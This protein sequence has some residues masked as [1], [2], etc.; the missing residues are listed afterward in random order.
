MWLCAFLCLLLPTASEEYPDFAPGGTFYET[1]N[2]ITNATIK[3]NDVFGFFIWPSTDPSAFVNVAV[4]PGTTNTPVSIRTV[5]AYTND[6]LFVNNTYVNGSYSTFTTEFNGLTHLLSTQPYQVTAGVTYHLKLALAD[7]RDQYIDSVVYLRAGSIAFSFPPPPPPSPP[8]PP[9][10]PSPPPNPPPV[11]LG[12]NSSSTAA[13][14]TRSLPVVAT[15]GAMVVL[16]RDATVSSRTAAAAADAAAAAASSGT[17]AGV[18]YA[19]AAAQSAGLLKRTTFMAG[20]SYYLSTGDGLAVGPRAGV[21][22]QRAFNWT[23]DE[24]AGSFKSVVIMAGDVTVLL[25]S[26]S[27]TAASG[28]TMPCELWAELTLTSEVFPGPGFSGNYDWQ[29]RGCARQWQGH[30]SL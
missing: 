21:T 19:Q 22:V 13:G 1:V 6:Q 30:A 5:N 7:G 15:G 20:T 2:P 10:S 17:A 12:S 16:G 25:N 8:P 9:P 11:Q 24:G 23:W 27:G 18:A 3:P 28:S 4:L 26:S 14:I 29:V